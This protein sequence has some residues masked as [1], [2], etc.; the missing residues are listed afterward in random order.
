MKLS[1]KDINEAAK[2]NVLQELGESQFKKNKPAVKAISETFKDGVNWAIKTLNPTDDH[3]LHLF[4]EAANCV[5]ILEDLDETNIPENEKLWPLLNAEL[6]AWRKE[7]Q[8]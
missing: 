1:K 3:R 4:Q 8:S 5:K 7:A 6:S 2:A